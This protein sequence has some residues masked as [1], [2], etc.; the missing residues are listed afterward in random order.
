MKKLLF[1]FAVLFAFAFNLYAQGKQDVIVVNKTGVTINEL[2]IT[3][4]DADEWGEDILGRDVLGLDE[5]CDIQ[6][7]PKENIC[8][9]DLRVADSD[10]NSLEWDKIDLCKAVRIILHWDGNKAWAD[11]EE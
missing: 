6:F 1:T 8:F 7:H 9:W 3:P 10:G 5:E 11:I 2:H 4:N